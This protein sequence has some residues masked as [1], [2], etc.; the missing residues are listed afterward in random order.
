[1]DSPGLSELIRRVAY[2]ASAV[3]IAQ[4]GILGHDGVLDPMPTLDLVPG[5]KKHLWEYD[6]AVHPGF[7]LRA[8]ESR[9]TLLDNICVNDSEC[10]SSINQCYVGA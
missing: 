4:R 5:Y 10:G 2:Q 9:S 7:D 1:L 8:Y 3:N 6:A